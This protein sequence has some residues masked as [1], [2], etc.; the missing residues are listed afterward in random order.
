MSDMPKSNPE[1]PTPTTSGSAFAPSPRQSKKIER[2]AAVLGK[3]VTA[4]A[5]FQVEGTL[6]WLLVGLGL[7]VGLR[8]GALGAVIGVIIGYLSSRLVNRRRAN[9]VS[10]N[11][12]LAVTN[13]HVHALKA[14]FWTNRPTGEQIGEWPSDQVGSLIRSKRL[15]IAVTLD[16]PDGRQMQLETPKSRGAGK[17]S[18]T[19]T[20]Q[21]PTPTT[22]RDRM[23]QLP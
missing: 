23:T 6:P 18:R 11:T 12:I 4:T 8:G 20:A 10:D 15:T 21:Q 13:N 5:V 3:P 17:W 19:L 16:L 22:D 14:S 1:Y 2:V 7:G 9:G